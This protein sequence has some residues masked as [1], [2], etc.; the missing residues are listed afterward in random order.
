MTFSPDY[1]AARDRFRSAAVRLGWTVH[2]HPITARGPGGEELTIDAAVSSPA[3]REPALVVSSG[4]HGVE[5]FFGSAVQAAALDEWGRTG[6]PAGVRCVFLHAVSPFGFAHRRR[7]DE[8]N[9][10]LNRNFLLDGEKFVG[11]SPTYAALDHCAE[12]APA[13][14]PAGLVR[15]AGD[16]G[17][18]AATGYGPIKQAVA[19]GQYD[20]PKG[21]FFGGHG[22][23]RESTHSPRS[24]RRLALRR[25]G[26][27]PSRLPH[28]AGPVGDVQAAGRG[29][30]PAGDG[31]AGG[32]MVR[33]GGVR[34]VGAARGGVP[35][36]RRV[37]RV[38]PA[39]RPASGTTCSSS[40]SSG[41]TRS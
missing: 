19:G 20:F 24:L 22:P 6:P 18:P 28:R 34:A 14:V 17:D 29:R 23:S 37:R 40:P 31:R 27:G 15:A 5:G 8:D 25:A 4:V 13:A 38:V 7:F 33:A 39:W 11:C 21:I 1:F 9:V 16:G 35:H 12:P 30:V 3:G 10:D 26:G 36:S 41:R 2:T 32:A